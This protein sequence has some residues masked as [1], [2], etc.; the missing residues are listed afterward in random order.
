MNLAQ[1]YSWVEVS[2]RALIAN[3]RAHR[4]L[5]GRKVKLMA[6][7]KSNAYGHGIE[8]VSQ[9]AQESSQ[10][11]WLGTAS[12]TE[13]KTIRRVKVKL[14]ILVLS[15]FRPFVPDDLVWAIKNKISFMVYEPEQ[16]EALIKAASK[17]KRP[18]WVHLELETGM[19]RLGLM[20]K[21]AR[22]FLKRIL[23][24]HHLKLEGI[25]SHFATAE[26]KDQA[27]LK[28]QLGAYRRFVR[29]V[30]PPLAA[31]VLQHMACS[32]AITAAP[33]THLSL[34]RLG[35]ALYGLWPSA[36][37]KQ[38]V[39][40]LRPDF[41]LK[42]PLIW[43]TQV[44]EVQRLAKGIP[45]GYARHY[46]TRRPTTMAGLPVGYWDGYGRGLSNRG[47]VLI[48]GVRCPIIGNVC[49]NISMVDASAVPKVRAVDEAVLIGKQGRPRS[50]GAGQDKGEVTADRLAELTHTINYEVVTRI[51]PLLPRILL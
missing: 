39:R 36:E 42:P 17:A 32:A 7:V 14:P 20:P 38:L 26:A 25:A 1:T 45:V 31:T 21:D 12:L 41:E 29:T 24:S 16:L 43:K 11:D 10:V 13:A 3:I 4:R 48:R 30:D 18:A 40:K 22:A 8:L 47:V 46:I 2:R 37:N 49:M 27:F 9:V 44:V 34:V 33:T 5:I 35:I 6:V 51:N 19:A 50:A 23:A 28:K 15:F